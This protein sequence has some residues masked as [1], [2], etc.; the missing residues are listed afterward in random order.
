MGMI[1]VSDQPRSIKDLQDA[2]DAVNASI[3]RIMNVPSMLGVMLPTI[4]EALIELI[5]R[6]EAVEEDHSFGE[7]VNCKFCDRHFH[8]GDVHFHEGYYVCEICWDERLS[9]TG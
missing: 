6:R 4:R 2:L 3:V 9:I 5:R 8:V 1:D 7:D